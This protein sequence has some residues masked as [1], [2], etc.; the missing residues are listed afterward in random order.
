MRP[1]LWEALSVL[2]AALLT[3]CAPRGD[4]GMHH[5]DRLRPGPWLMQLDL[6][7]STDKGPVVLPFTF[8]VLTDS[9][10]GTALRIRNG[11]EIIDVDEVR[12]DGDSIRVHM[13]LFDSEFIGRLHGDTA[14][15]GRWFN[16]LRGPGYSIPFAAH[17]GPSARFAGLSG[18]NERVA[19]TWA[20]H[21]APGTPDAY[22]AVGLFEADAERVTGTFGTETGDH[23]FLEG[24]MRADS[25][26]L[27]SFDGSHAYL[28]RAVLRNDSLIGEFRSGIHSLEPWHAVRD[29]DFQLRDPDSLTFLKE[30]YDMVDIRLPDLQGDTISLMDARFEGRVRMVQIM[31]SWCPNC[32][33]ESRLLAQMHEQYH[34]AG[35]DVVAVAFEREADPVRAVEMLKRYQHRLQIPY[36]ILY[37][38]S[39]KK[40][41][42]AAK[43]PFLNHLMS[44]PTCIFIDRLGK[45]RR[46]RTG[47]YGPSTGQ[48]YRN[49]QHNL[50]QFLERMLAEPAH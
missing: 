11:A 33:D 29:P 38:G 23:R 44:Y 1:F 36:D 49:Y 24:G 15:N 25:F 20:C 18:D 4:E 37:A 48:H 35:L 8:E 16:Y 50:E 9:A 40:E 45:V 28:F 17:A 30:G 14:I 26:L 41:E 43:L 21:F 12:I 34:N 3:S 39:S 47:F 5:H 10:R 7:T 2:A 22:D 42:V 19:G 46:I 27:S 32:M 31:G 13:P 6:R